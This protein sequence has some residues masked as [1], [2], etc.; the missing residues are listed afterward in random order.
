M[1][2]KYMGSV[3]GELGN[4]LASGLYKKEYINRTLPEG[5]DPYE[6]REGAI[7]MFMDKYGMTREEADAQ[8][9][10]NYREQT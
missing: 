8:F 6:V 4:E 7:K 2:K 9:W 5:V 10:K 1:R 3:F